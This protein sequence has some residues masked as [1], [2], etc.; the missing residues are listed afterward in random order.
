[1]KQ[2][3]FSKGFLHFLIALIILPFQQTLPEFVK[4]AFTP[5]IFYLVFTKNPIFIPALIAFVTPGTTISFAVLISTFVITLLSISDLKNYGLSK[6]LL[7]SF[8]PLPFFLYLTYQRLFELG[9]GLIGTLVPLDYYLGLFPF[10]YGVLC[11]RK[12]GNDSLWGIILALFILPLLNTFQIIDFSV[13]VF[14]L[15]YPIFLTI[16]LSSIYLF[17]TNKKIDKGLFILSVLFLLVHLSPKFT[18][19]F[20]GIVGLSVIYLKASNRQFYLSILTG[21]KVVVLFLAIV[22]LI[23]TNTDTAINSLNAQNIS[24]DESSYYESWETFKEKLYFKSFGDRAPIWAGAWDMLKEETE[25]YFYP[26][27]EPLKYSMRTLSGST[28]DENELAIHNLLL[29]LMRN[30]GF[31]IGISIFMIFIFY[32]VLGPGKFIFKSNNGHI[33]LIFLAAG[34]F[35]SGIV[36]SLVGQYPLMG[37]FSIG[38]ISICGVFYG[39]NFSSAIEDHL[40]WKK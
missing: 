5:Y 21:R 13:R 4:L 12:F 19:L 35:G 25:Y 33:A 8:L 40:E 31:L 28:I 7:L 38:M 27:L 15:S 18:V 20:S 32:L 22:F 16:F 24:Y 6:I 9:A 34:T 14:W 39:F 29:E 36:G 11:Y 17:I 23:I 3:L 26:P 1:M 10:F 2:F 37:T 30:F